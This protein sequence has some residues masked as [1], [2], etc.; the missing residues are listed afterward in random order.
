M[1]T[2]LTSIFL[3][4]SVLLMPLVAQE[5]ITASQWQEDLRYLQDNVHKEYSFLFKKVTAETF[6]TEVD[7]L[8]EAIPDME[9]HE[10]PVAI[11]RIVSLFEYGH[12]QVPF[13]SITNGKALPVNLYHF[14]DGVFIEGTQKAYAKA[15]GARVVAVEGIPIDKALEMVRP[16]VPVENEQYFRGYGL[17]FLTIPAILHAQG[18]TPSLQTAITMTLENNGVTYEQSFNEI[19]LDSLSRDYGWT[20]P[21]EAWI[22]MRD[23][24]ETPLYL[25]H[26]KDKFYFFEYLADT[27]TLYVRQSSVFNDPNNESLSD[28]YTRLFAFVDSHEIDSFIYDVRLNGGG[29]NYNNKPLIKGIM[30]RPKI[31]TKGKFFYI[32]G[33]NTFSA[34]QNLTNEIGNYTEAILIGE[35]TSENVNFYG[36][37]RKVTLPHSQLNAY[38]SYAWWQDY[39]QWENKDAT[40]PNLA[41]SM[42]S[43]EYRTNQDPVLQAALG[44]KDDGFILNPLEYLRQLFI[45]GKYTELRTASKEIAQNPAYKYYDFESEFSEAGYRLYQIGNT[46]GGL[47][48]LELVA[49]VFPTSTTA[50]HTVASVQ[51]QMKLIEKA[52]AS[53]QKVI[54]LDPDSVLGKTAQKK[55]SKL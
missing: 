44:Y 24:K 20:L 51:E 18:V 21:N 25:K 29:N 4:L 52:K 9:A 53:Y 39:P 26:L 1:H 48:I 16:V 11:S 17:R 27:K 35:P 23:Q 47:Y 19:P 12:S 33:R 41:V 34:C 7:K 8:Y 46:E 15:L 22:S 31:N 54:D 6:D 55:L 32:I 10:I 49:D 45:E 42:T 14:S 30:A 40:I 28:F 37:A 36:D 3:F 2:T 13:G 38:L 5:S 43:E 50:W